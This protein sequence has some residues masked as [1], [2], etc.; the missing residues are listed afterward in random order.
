LRGLTEKKNMTHNGKTK[1]LLKRFELSWR[2]IV[3]HFLLLRKILGIIFRKRKKFYTFF[4]RH[5]AQMIH[6]LM[7]TSGIAT[8]M[9]TVV[10]YR[11][12][13]PT[14]VFKLHFKSIHVSIM[15]FIDCS[16]TRR[17]HG[18]VSV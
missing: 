8:N 4:K 6:T 16:V 9:L 18:K 10:F 14:I 15:R 7:L 11:C 3:Y 5:T 1:A 12:T 13:G 2:R 17:D